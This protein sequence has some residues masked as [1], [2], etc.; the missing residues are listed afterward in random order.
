MPLFHFSFIFSDF[1]IS[2]Y[3]QKCH[4]WAFTSARARFYC[5][6]KV[7][8]KCCHFCLFCC[9]LAV[10]TTSIAICESEKYSQESGKYDKLRAQKGLTTH[11][12]TDSWGLLSTHMRHC[13]RIEI[14]HSRCIVVVVG[15]H[16]WTCTYML[17]HRYLCCLVG[18]LCEFCDARG[19]S[20]NC[21]IKREFWMLLLKTF[22]QRR[23][24]SSKYDHDVDD[25]DV[26]VM[27]LTDL[28]L[29]LWIQLLQ[30]CYSWNH[31]KTWIN[32]K[33]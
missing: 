22:R 27:L 33:E 19:I 7:H 1:L 12:H 6:L 18:F 8:F 15:P 30:S 31:N 16:F 17:R 23:A 11:T 9:C 20:S 4:V 3:K 21:R 10:C 13:F 14:A 29:Y 2:F 28:I 5:L 25:D 24:L 32:I 26:E